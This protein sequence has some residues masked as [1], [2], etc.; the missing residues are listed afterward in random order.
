M[1]AEERKREKDKYRR[2]NGVEQK[3]RV[4]VLLDPTAHAFAGWENKAEPWS[5]TTCEEYI[6][7]AHISKNFPLVRHKIHRQHNKCNLTFC[8]S[9]EFINRCVEVWRWLYEK[10]SVTRNEVGLSL[11][12]M[13]YAEVALGK[14]VDWRTIKPRSLNRPQDGFIPRSWGTWTSSGIGIVRHEECLAD[15]LV[16]WSTQSS[17]DERTHCTPNERSRIEGRLPPNVEVDPLLFDV[18]DI[19]NIEKEMHEERGV[20]EEEP[21]IEDIM[22][23][24]RESRITELEALVATHELTIQSL[25]DELEVVPRS[26]ESTIKSL[27][28]AIEEKDLQISEL[29][30]RLKIQEGEV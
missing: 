13:V 7:W 6:D 17:A 14:Q 30:E 27:E 19:E 11:A 21:N 26:F 18:G 8:R 22:N 24:S 12:R 28:D 15:Q 16:L 25:R 4:Y 23:K 3:K 5:L 2:R 1:T 10:P 29:T 20:E 9:N